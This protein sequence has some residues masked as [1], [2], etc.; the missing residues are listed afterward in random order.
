MQT[1]Y[2]TREEAAE[3]LGV[4]I[5]QLMERRREPDPLPAFQIGRRILF[6]ASDIDNWMEKFRV[7]KMGEELQ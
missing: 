2:L 1:K 3:Y 4:S 6:R 7:K 5:N